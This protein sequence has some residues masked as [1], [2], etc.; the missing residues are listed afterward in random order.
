MTRVSRI[1]GATMAAVTLCA[2]YAGA[3]EKISP[4]SD[5]QYKKD[6]AQVEGILKEADLQKRADMLVAFQKQHPISKMLDYVALQYLECVKPYVQKKDWAR[7]VSME[8]GFLNLMPTEKTV[9]D[10]GIPVGVDEFLKKQL[11]PSQKQ[12]YQALM[13]AY[14]QSN[15][16]PKAAEMA[17][18]SYALAPDK[19]MAATLADIYL[20]MQNFDKYLAYGD[21]VLAEFPIAQSYGMALQ[22]M[23]ICFQRQNNAKGMELLSKVVEAFPD[24]APEGVKP[25]EWNIYLATY[26]APKAAEAYK[27]KDYAKAIELFEKVIGF[28]PK[29][30]DTPYYFIGMSKWN[31]KD[32]DGAIPY[33]AKAMVLGKAN[34]AKAKQYL[35]DLY[36]AR[37]NDSLDGLD[38]VVAKAKA[39]LGVS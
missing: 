8:E 28:S 3:Q 36:K 7:V 33:F 13:G 1:I 29:A 27:Q 38:Q 24:K 21:K 32:P 20:K 11:V 22:M 2:V 34:S 35:E 4:I 16:F 19:S 12:F 15:N 14:Y 31:S 5:Y 26:W 9:Q 25:E 10:A 6:Y 23:R 17:E 39:D 30:D 37:H 18:K